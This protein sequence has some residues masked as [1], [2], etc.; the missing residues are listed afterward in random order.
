[1][2]LAA[3]RNSS[4]NDSPMGLWGGHFRGRDEFLQ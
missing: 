2:G 4:R 3:S 1:M